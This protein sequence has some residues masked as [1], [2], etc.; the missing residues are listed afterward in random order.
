MP[1]PARDMRRSHPTPLKAIPALL[2]L[3]A[4]ALLL[5]LPSTAAASSQTAFTITGRG[6]GHGIGMSQ[7]GA[8]GLAQHGLTY[9]AILK[10]YYTGIG[11]SSIDNSQLR[12]RLR[13]G[14]NTVKLTCPNDFTVRGSAA[15]FTIPG[16]TAATVTYVN[17]KYRVTAGNWS[18]DFTAAVTF[19]PT[20][21]SLTMITATDLGK[22]G[23]YRG[24]IR[25]IRSG[26]DFMVINQVRMESYL[27]GVVPHEVSPSWPKEALR[28]QACAARA[29]AERA[30]RS[31]TGAWDLY[32]DVRSQVYSGTA[33]EDPRSDAAVAATAGV[34]PSY[35]G[36]PIQAFYFSSSGGMTE[37]IE[38]AW[39]TQPSPYLKSV[40]DP[41][42][43]NAPLHKWGPMRKTP[44][45]LA[46]AL[47]SAV[48]GS[49]AAIVRVEQ[50]KSPR[51]VKAAIIGSTGTTYMH[52]SALRVK[53]ALN[54]AWV[55]F[56]SM[57]IAPAA[58]DAVKITKGT[59]V[60]LSGRVYPVLASGATV[61]LMY[62]N[63]ETWRSVNVTTVRHVRRLPDG[64][65]TRYSSYRTTVTPGQTTQYYFASGTA[66][67]PTTT[68]DVR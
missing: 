53:L 25:V 48:K 60:T 22:G 15:S 1:Q 61:K 40:N 13:S 14:V 58:R 36:S 54:S 64:Y 20:Q 4:L 30:R 24:A 63:G 68:I 7:W 6:W 5:A 12:V 17:S 29:Y 52:G 44:S 26:T 50:G 21:G 59:G 51:I 10:H 19:A 47:G 28:A 31:A 11:F 41:Y 42:D 37:N 45:S 23:K 8:Y 62:K 9:K 32:T 35:Q 43:S 46:T 66:K 65:S 3:L 16:G 39:V 27:R 57:S 2:L 38:L 18:R 34:V 56:K 67:S 55:T 49:L 33:L